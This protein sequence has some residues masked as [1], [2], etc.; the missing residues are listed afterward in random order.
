V[1]EP[2]AELRQLVATEHGLPKGSA[3]FLSGETLEQ[4]EESA[5]AFENLLEQHRGQESTTNVLDAVAAVKGARQRALV[6]LV[7]GRAPQQPRDERGRFASGGFDGGARPGLPP[8]PESHDEMLLR[9]LRSR[10][11]D[12]GAAG[13]GR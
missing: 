8:A 6:N 7:T 9:I 2:A 11:A 12:R 3:G 1:S 5:T 4:I 10:E 13:F